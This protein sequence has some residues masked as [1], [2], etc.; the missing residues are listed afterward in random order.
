MNSTYD[1]ILE[2]IDLPRARKTIRSAGI[3]VAVVFDRLAGPP[4]VMW[5]GGGAPTERIGKLRRAFRV[6]IANRALSLVDRAPTKDPAFP[7]SVK[8]EFVCRVQDPLV[9]VSDG[10]RDMT[11]AVRPSLT[12]IIR[13]ITPHF[14]TLESTRAEEAITGELLTLPPMLGV[15]LG[16]FAVTV[17]LVDAANIVS[18]HQENRVH[19]MRYDT[20]L[21]IAEGG[22]ETQ[23]AHHMA[24]N[25]GDASDFLAREQ[26]GMLTALNLL[27]GDA[28]LDDINAAALTDHTIGALF[29]GREPKA[30]KSAGI[31]DRIASKQRAI[32]DGKVVDEPPSSE[33]PDPPAEPAPGGPRPS[34]IKGTASGRHHDEA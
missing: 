28:E 15:V 9:I 13:R 1:P 22:R 16:G 27:R 5:P 10:I 34:R 33:K 11:A 30:L 24:L 32:E 4:M 14:D 17:G 12:A 31:R 25:E 8:V 2:V 23:L 21:P 29:P 19:R 20:M 18:V 6:D 7:F 26:A 3:G